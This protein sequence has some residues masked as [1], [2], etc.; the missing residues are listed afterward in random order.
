MSEDLQIYKIR[1]LIYE[2]IF[3]S[4][5]IDLKEAPYVFDLVVLKSIK[6]IVE[7]HTANGDLHPKIINNIGDFLVQARF[8]DDEYKNER[9]S[10]IN[11]IITL[12]NNQKFDECLMF[13][14]FQLYSRRKEIKYLFASN[15]EI[16]T[17]IDNVHDSICHDLYVIT[18]HSSEFSDEDFIKEAIPFLQDS[19][20]YYESLN[21]ILKENPAIFKDL[22]FYNRMICI[23]NINNEI[24]KENE[25]MYQHN[26]K[27]V[28]KI[29]KKVKKA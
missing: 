27:L 16:M 7:Y 29:D 15:E 5:K 8:Y 13:Y 4:E 28:K 20:L 19:N 26:K 17:E 22:T 21:M 2:L 10:I 1:K 14:R 12:M 9:F 3:N 11:D 6:N 23:L 18:S 25:K 24:Y